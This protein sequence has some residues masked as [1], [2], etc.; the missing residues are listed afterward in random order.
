MMQ[1][2]LALRADPYL[3]GQA[4]TLL[5][6]SFFILVTESHVVYIAGLGVFT[7]VGAL[8]LAKW[9]VQARDATVWD[10]TLVALSLGYGL[11]TLNTEL[12]WIHQS[13]DY[14]S[15]TSAQPLYVMRTAGWLMMLGAAL[16]LMSGLDHKGI[17][18]DVSIPS[19]HLP[20]C[21]VLV[22][23]VALAA[24]AQVATGAIGYH[25]DMTDG[26][27]R[28]SPLATLTVSLICPAAALASYTQRDL[29]G[30][31]RMLM[32]IGLSILMVIQFYQGRR[33]FIYTTLLCMLCLFAASPSKRFV[34]MR[35]VMVFCIAALAIMI[36]SKAFFALRMALWELG[37]SRDTVALLQ[38]GLGI[39]LD[40]KRAG[41]SE[42]IEKNQSFRTF[43]IGYPAELLQALEDHDPLY[44]EVL[45]FDLALN[46][47]AVLWSGK[48]KV[49]SIGAEEAIANPHF[50][51]ELLD[52]ANSIV[53]SG[54]SD[55]GMLGFFVYPLAL[56]TL[57]RQILKLGRRLGGVPYVMLVASLVNTLM[58]IEAATSDYFNALRNLALV[59][60][61]GLS[62]VLLWRFVVAPLRTENE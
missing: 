16:C 6:A 18:A 32:W 47:P 55:F 20:L 25:Q 15:V 24:V 40:S 48:Y 11:G 38:T 10:I 45:K 59:G 14:V 4:T 42:E 49:V 52:Q 7:A 21:L 9:V 53:T 2:P 26:G 5:L 62:G 58:N 8:G 56:L 27:V 61:V 43:I 37:S 50:G 31:M 22:W 17:L 39:L 35:N 41:L 34:S 57:F 13:L 12:T 33:V 23:G 60:V 36:A 51:L 3:W 30:R 46:V 1:K 44:G 19:T 29:H 28:V 54:L